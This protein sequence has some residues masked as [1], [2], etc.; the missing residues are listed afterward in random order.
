MKKTTLIFCVLATLFNSSPNYSME[1]DCFSD[2]S[3]EDLE[4][5]QALKDMR[6]FNFGNGKVKLV[7]F[8][9]YEEAKELQ[10]DVKKFMKLRVIC[11]SLSQLLT[12]ERI[13]SFCRHY[14]H[15]AKNIIAKKIASYY[16]YDYEKKRFPILILVY[17]GA[18]AR[19]KSY[20]VYDSLLAQAV[21]ESDEE[22]VK[23]L[24]GHNVNS[25]LSP[26]FFK[27]KTVEVAQLF[28]DGHV[29]IHAT[30]W[31]NQNVLWTIIEELY[32]SDLM[33]FYLAR[34][35]NAK[36]LR[37]DDSASLLHYLGETVS[38]RRGFENIEEVDNFLQNANILLTIIP[39]MINKLDD[40]DQTPLDIACGIL[41]WMQEELQEQESCN[42]E[43]GIEGLTKLITL[44]Q[45]SGAF[46]D[47]E[48]KGRV[49]KIKTHC[50][51][52]GE[53]R[54]PID[55]GLRK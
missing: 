55:Q 17:A 15:K 42:L 47:Q 32:P 20:N 11:K 9:D 19:I 31:S 51:T 40:F 23:I 16:R 39:V 50:I 29:N 10:N 25:D 13:G 12:G 41:K 26:L 52:S 21:Y 18:N 49:I 34:G 37:G 22:L 28:I 43:L 36:I 27:A 2:A 35:V 8:W 7:K 30:D 24:L 38:V 6:P 14:S 54:S 46:T 5:Q 1:I 48:L 44:F 45:K 53:Q 3:S 4:I 33:R